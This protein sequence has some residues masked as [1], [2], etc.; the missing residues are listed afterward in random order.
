MANPDYRGTGGGTTM[1]EAYAYIESLLAGTEDAEK[2]TPSST[3]GR[4]YDNGS[5]T[6][7]QVRELQNYYEVE[8]DGLWGKNSTAAA[9]GQSAE[10]AWEEYRRLMYPGAP[11]T[12]VDYDPE[13]GAYRWNGRAYEDLAALEQGI[14]SA[15]LTTAELEELARELNELGVSTEWVR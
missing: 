15:G 10:Q 6:R 5:L 14:N 7:E 3:D 11:S 13:S 12:G 2:D 1:A 8:A 9:G 4:T